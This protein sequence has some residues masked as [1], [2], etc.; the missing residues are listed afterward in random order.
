MQCKTPHI[1]LVPLLEKHGLSWELYSRKGR[2]PKG[3]R[4]VA[5]KGLGLR[6]VF[7]VM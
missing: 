7:L 3:L 5:E 6:L 2:L 1:E 4:W